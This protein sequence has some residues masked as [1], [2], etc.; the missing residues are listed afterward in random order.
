MMNLLNA[1]VLENFNFASHQIIETKEPLSSSRVQRRPIEHVA[2]I[3]EVQGDDILA[4][5]DGGNEQSKVVIPEM[6]DSKSSARMHLHF[7]HER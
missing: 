1:G 7:E 4:D 6:I 5:D 2:I 3:Y